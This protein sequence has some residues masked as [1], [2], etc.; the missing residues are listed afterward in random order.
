MIRNRYCRVYFTILATECGAYDC[1]ATKCDDCT[2]NGAVVK[3]T[4]NG[5]VVKA[6]TVLRKGGSY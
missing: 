5:A 4:G 3:G 2:G 6:S 1:D